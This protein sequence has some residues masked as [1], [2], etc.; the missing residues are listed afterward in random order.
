MGDGSCHFNKAGKL[1]NF[2]LCPCSVRTQGQGSMK[3]TCDVSL[4]LYWPGHT[5]QSSRI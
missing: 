2:K 5:Y 3:K 1:V 4:A